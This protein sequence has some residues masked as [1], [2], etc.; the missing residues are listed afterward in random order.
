MPLWIDAQRSFVTAEPSYCGFFLKDLRNFMMFSIFLDKS[1][2][3][4]INTHFSSTIDTVQNTDT[5][6]DVVFDLF[7]RRVYTITL[8]VFVCGPPQ[9]PALPT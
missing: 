4:T 3:F 9:S 5:G 1:F 7:S 2:Y 6:L 8:C